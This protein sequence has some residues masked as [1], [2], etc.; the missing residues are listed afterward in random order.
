MASAVGGHDSGGP[1]KFPT[2]EEMGTP[3]AL[4]YPVESPKLYRRVFHVKQCIREVWLGKRD[5][6]GGVFDVLLHYI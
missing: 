3:P 1:I 5:A 2:S 4:S 6:T